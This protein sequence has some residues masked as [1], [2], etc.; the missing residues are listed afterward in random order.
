MSDTIRAL[1]ARPGVHRVVV[2]SPDGLPVE[3][4][5]HEGDAE[6]LAALTSALLKPAERLATESGGTGLARMVLEFEGGFAL[7]GAV[8]GGN[9]LVVLVSAAADV[10]EILFELRQ[11][12]PELAAQL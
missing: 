6:A 7:L 11:Q 9:W 12:G 10:G 3:S 8:R 1:A 2:A 5:G 4:A